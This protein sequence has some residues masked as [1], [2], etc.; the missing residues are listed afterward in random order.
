MSASSP[1]PSPA[2]AHFPNQIEP[3][4]ASHPLLPLL[5]A[6]DPGYWQHPPRSPL[7]FH[8]RLRSQIHRVHVAALDEDGWRRVERRR[9]HGSSV[10]RQPNRRQIPAGMV[11]RCFNCLAKGHRKQS[12]HEPTRCLRCGQAGHRSFECARPRRAPAATRAEACA[13]GCWPVPRASAPIFRHKPKLM[14]SGEAKD[15]VPSAGVR[16][17]ATAAE[18]AGAVSAS[19]SG[20]RR[21]TPKKREPLHRGGQSPPA[22]LHSTL[23]PRVGITMLTNAS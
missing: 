18:V 1:S 23:G 12:C 14:A 21:R 11:G 4:A 19:T 15:P 22:R 10:A 9:N 6:Y 16:S 8:I 3:L 2:G 13:N 7:P 17:V 20:V 5:A